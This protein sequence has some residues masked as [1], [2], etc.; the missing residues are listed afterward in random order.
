MD[1]AQKRALL[2]EINREIPQDVDWHAGAKRYVQAENK[3]YGKEPYQRF[4]LSKPFGRVHPGED[5][6]A[7]LAEDIYYLSNFAN[8]A[9]LLNLPGSA[10][11]LDVACGS[12]WISHFLAL[13]DYDVY[14]FDI[15]PDMLELTHERFRREPLFDYSELDLAS[16]FFAL[17]I[18]TE[19][20]PDRLAGSFDAIVLESCMHHFVDPISAMSHIAAGLKEDG[21]VMILEGEA[22]QGPIGQNFMEV[23]REF[24]TLERS[25]TRSH[26]EQ[27][28]DLAGLPHREF[29][30]RGLGWMSDRDPN[31][32]HLPQI[33]K[34]EAD[35]LNFAV[36]G[37]TARALDR[38]F[39]FRTMPPFL[40]RLSFGCPIDFSE[41]G[42][43]AFYIISGWS[44]Q[45]ANFR[46]TDGPTA[47][48]RVRLEG[49]PNAQALGR[50]YLRFRAAS[51]GAAQRVL[52]TIDGK[53]VS[54]LMLTADRRDYEI[55]VDLE[56]PD[57]DFEHEIVFRLPDAHSPKSVGLSRDPRQLGMAMTSLAFFDSARTPGKCD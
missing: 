18:E 24:D 54:E 42:N 8:M 20:L 47:V 15:A 7:S 56:N 5:G 19:P 32:G 23:M 55:E 12:G 16:R 40:R 39:P 21:L 36:C 43:S 41:N 2:A 14:G 28:L 17:N 4:L 29:L 30:A 25:Y 35:G 46:W 53:Q 1:E 3:K 22:R 52:V 49:A 50:S 44:H 45:E 37:K 13:M 34:T 26:F 10:R 11:V 38:V 33:M 51:F 6:G 48:L 9:Q 27:I 31:I 57:S